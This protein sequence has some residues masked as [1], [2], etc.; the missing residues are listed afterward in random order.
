MG[1]GGVDAAL[2]SAAQ[3]AT[4][5]PAPPRPRSAIFAANVA[6]IDAHNKA[7]HAWRMG[8][9]A[10]A[11]LTGEEFKARYTGGLRAR[12]HEPRNVDTTLL[13]RASANPASVDW[14]S[15]GAVTPIKNQGQCGSCW[16]FSTTGSVEGISFIKTGALR[17]V[18]WCCGGRRRRPHPL[19]SPSHTRPARR[20]PAVPV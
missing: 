7:G 20:H 18:G 17:A 16:A 9:N 4:R 6:K 1:G 8:V 3:R 5:R 12:E 14:S 2:R 15:K 10:F 11:D 13:G 19:A